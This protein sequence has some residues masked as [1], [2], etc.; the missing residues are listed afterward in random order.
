MIMWFLWTA[1][2]IRQDIQCRLLQFADRKHLLP[3]LCSTVNGASSVA[4]KLHSEFYWQ[5]FNIQPKYNNIAQ[6]KQ[7]QII[8]FHPFPEYSI[9][10][11]F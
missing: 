7:V 6:M 1:G 10:S 8:S 9:F 11:A 4:R 2:V 3:T 5:L